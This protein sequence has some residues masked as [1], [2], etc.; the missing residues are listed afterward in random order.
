MAFTGHRLLQHATRHELR[1]PM[2]I[3]SLMVGAS[4]NS[5]DRHGE[6]HTLAALRQLREELATIDADRGL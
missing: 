1:Y 6:K 5:G 4:H 2:L 3:H